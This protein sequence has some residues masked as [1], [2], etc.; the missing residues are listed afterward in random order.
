MRDGALKLEHLIIFQHC[1][2]DRVLYHTT[3]SRDENGQ[4]S[5]KWGDRNARREEGTGK[6]EGEPGE[7]DKGMRIRK[8]RGRI[9]GEKGE[10]MVRKN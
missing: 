5:M 8:G 2:T 1:Y 6:E 10:E 4:E 3:P 9:K 7:V